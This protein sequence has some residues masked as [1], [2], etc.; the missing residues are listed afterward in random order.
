MSLQVRPSAAVRRAW[1]KGRT[2]DGQCFLGRFAAVSKW[3]RTTAQRTT[4][5]NLFHSP[6]MTAMRL[7]LNELML[8][9]KCETK[10]S[11]APSPPGVGIPTR[12]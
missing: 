5:I 11:I 3:V 9:K 10:D 2:A 1:L 6:R 7:A 8:S 4:T 12:F